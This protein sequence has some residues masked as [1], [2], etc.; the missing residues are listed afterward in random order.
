[1]ILDIQIAVSSDLAESVAAR[2]VERAVAD[3]RAGYVEEIQRI[4]EGTYRVI[5]RTGQVDPSLRDIL[6]ECRLSTAGFYKCFRSKDELLLLLLDDGRRTL[7]SYLGHRMDRATTPEGRVRAWVDGVVAQASHPDAASRTL[8]FL[9]NQDRLAA[10]FPEEQQR[11]VDS[12]LDLLAGAVHDVRPGRRRDTDRRDAEAVYHLAFG[13]LHV[14]L[15]RGTAPTAPETE[16]L[17]RFCLQGIGT[18]NQGGTP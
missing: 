10:S 12:L 1:M 3:R 6:K 15:R 11:S 4:V 13:A 8:P 18:D 16:H 14:A 5:E 9:S 2:A 7:L 17:V